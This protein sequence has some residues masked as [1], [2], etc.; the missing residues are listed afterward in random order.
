VRAS[1]LV[2]DLAEDRKPGCTDESCFT[3]LAHVLWQLLGPTGTSNSVVEQLTFAV[4]PPNPMPENSRASSLTRWPARSRVVQA[5][6]QE[7]PIS[8]A[9]TTPPPSRVTRSSYVGTAPRPD[10]ATIPVPTPPLTLSVPANAPSV[11]V[12]NRS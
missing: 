9:R 11:E 4:Q 8:V 2:P 3:R 10:R 5:L 6:P 1:D 12:E 7:M